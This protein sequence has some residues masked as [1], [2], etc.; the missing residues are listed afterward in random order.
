MFL[1]NTP[2]TAPGGGPGSSC[3]QAKPAGRRTRARQCIVCCFARRCDRRPARPAERLRLFGWARPGRRGGCFRRNTLLYAQSLKAKSPDLYD[4]SVAPGQREHAQR[5]IR[6]QRDG[7]LYHGCAAGRN[8]ALR[9]FRRASG[10]GQNRPAATIAA[11]PE[12]NG[13]GGTRRFLQYISTIRVSPSYWMERA[14]VRTDFSRSQRL[15]RK[16]ALSIRS[17]CTARICRS[18]DSAR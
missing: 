6:F 11:R 17:P 2:D 1:R 15:A 18:R 14:L 3:Q 13:G 4:F 16:N 12:E 7:I 5:R 10:T 9:L 8:G